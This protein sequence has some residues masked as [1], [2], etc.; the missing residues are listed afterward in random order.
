[1]PFIGKDWRAP[2]DLWVRVNHVNNTAGWELIKLRPIQLEDSL[3]KRENSSISLTSEGDSSPNSFRTS[4]EEEVEEIVGEIDI[5]QGGKI[6]S[7]KQEEENEFILNEAD[8]LE[9]ENGFNEA[10]EED[11]G[12]DED[13]D[14]DQSSA[15]DRKTFWSQPYCFVKLK[16]RSKEF[17]GCTSM[18][19]AFHRLDMARAVVDIRRFNYICK[20]VQILVNEKLHNLSASS[21]KILFAIIQ[22]MVLHSVEND[23]HITTTRDILKKFN[24][25]LDS[26]HVCGSPQLVSKQQGTCTNL[27]DLIA[28]SSAPHTL[29]E[30]NPENIT[31]LDLPRE[32]LS[33]ILSKLPDHVS[34]L[35]AAKAN[36]TLQAL[37]ESE[38]R[39]WKTLCQF[40]FSQLQINKHQYPGQSWR[41]LF[42][43]LKKYYGLRETYADLVVVCC[44]CKALFW[45]DHGHPCVSKDAPSV[46][47]TPQQVF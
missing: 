37:V 36:E 35:E 4:S 12:D 13:D 10:N 5:L 21:R 45:K 7:F 38:Q 6:I 19:E 1:M 30:A 44:H 23:V 26:P 3:P 46:R 32:V 24:S 2:G 18:S 11:E 34:L 20:V 28:R 31:F 39:Q 9:E 33:L 14:S 29:S 22:A 43:E 41:D 25:G 17:I 15:I 40:H 27:L 47:V 16:N 8:I 42:F